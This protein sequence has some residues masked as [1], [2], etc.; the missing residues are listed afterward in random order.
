[1]DG[2]LCFAS[3]TLAP[4]A[5]DIANLWATPTGGELRGNANIWSGN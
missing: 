5:G 1:M 4:T 3:I 2:P